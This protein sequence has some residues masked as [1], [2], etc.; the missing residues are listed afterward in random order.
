VESTKAEPGLGGSGAQLTSRLGMSKAFFLLE[1]EYIAVT[2]S[3]KIGVNRN[4][5]DEQLIYGSKGKVNGKA[6]SVIEQT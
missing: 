5:S 1:K 6:F 2:S 4:P 3:Y